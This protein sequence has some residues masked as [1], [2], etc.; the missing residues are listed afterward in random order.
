MSKNLSPTIRALLREDFVSFA[1][2]CFFELNPSLDFKPNWYIE[3]LAHELLACLAGERKRMIIA[4]PPRHGKST[5]ASVVFP[6]W[7]LGHNPS[8]RIIGASYGQEV[9]ARF[10]LDFRK[11]VE[12]D[13]YGEV[14]PQF[15]INSS[16][17]TEREVQTQAG[18]FRYATAFGGPLTAIGGDLL[19]LDD[20]IK[21][22]DVG[23]E[24]KRQHVMDWLKNT[25]FS[26][27]DNKS[28]GSIV[29]VG[30]RLHLQDPIGQLLAT[31]GWHAVVLPAIAEET[32]TY[33]LA[34]LKG[35][36]EYTRK[37][38]DLLDPD[39]EPQSVLD[40]LK[41][42]MGAPDFNAQYQQRPE[43]TADSF[44]L[45]DWF[46]KYKDVP[47]FDYLFLSVDPAIATTSTADWSV[48]MV[49][50]VLGKE[51]Y[52]LHVE[53]KRFGFNELALRLDQLATKY[54]AD[55]ILIERSGIGISLIKYLM[56]QRKHLILG[57]T[58]KGSKEERLISVLPQ[59]E[60]G[61]VLV[62]SEANWLDIMYNELAAFPNGV[63]DDQVD[64]L[65]QFLKYRDIC[66]SQAARKKIHQSGTPPKGG[67]EPGSVKVYGFG[68]GTTFYDRMGGSFP[69]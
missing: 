68:G 42:D 12:S 49:I 63:N 26:R 61:H 50:G 58:P 18:G 11:I 29:V 4:A 24:V 52:V 22:A 32:K 59:I 65:S 67:S 33:K 53:R 54:V 16:K 43:H 38:G 47:K 41:L 34:R 9:A 14:F 46:P 8:M 17:C 66:I 5:L 31:G 13:W 1:C 37:I 55:A 21:A 3:H 25:V 51:N 62:P 64:A 2:K 36:M 56:D 23:Y 19:I 44:I 27:L 40:Q 57:H 69:Y 60:Q 48:C 39:R 10:Q 6:A 20:V 45:W 35:D 7:C 28:K 15:Q 30:Q